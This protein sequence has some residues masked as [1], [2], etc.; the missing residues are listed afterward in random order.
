MPCECDN[1]DE[2]G[3]HDICETHVGCDQDCRAL[4]EPHSTEEI[5]SA[6]EH[7]RRHSYLAGY[8]HSC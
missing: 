3:W 4:L 6:Y 5:A 8:S 2:T 1:T 7:W